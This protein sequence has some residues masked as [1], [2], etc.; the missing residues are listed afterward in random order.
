[1]VEEQP[2]QETGEESSSTNGLS[3]ESS[4]ETESSGSPLGVG[5]LGGLVPIFGLGLAL[6]RVRRKN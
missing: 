6:S 2:A 1:V 3:G 4:A 5:C